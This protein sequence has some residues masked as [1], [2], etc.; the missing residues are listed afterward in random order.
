M[1]GNSITSRF[2]KAGKK[3]LALVLAV[4]LFA[5]LVIPG[6][7]INSNEEKMAGT[8]WSQEVP[9][10][11][12]VCVFAP[13]EAG[14]IAQ[15]IAVEVPDGATVYE[16]LEASGLEFVAS[17]SEYGKFVESIAGVAAGDFG[18]SSWWVYTVN[19]ETVMTGCDS[20]ELENGDS[21]EWKYMV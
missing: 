9:I 15:E 17:D 3:G 21:V 14:I 10:T 7:A 2:A 1:N 20:Y 16:A 8:Q 5:L 11:V 6:C 19:G 4:V 13:E 18:D 12:N